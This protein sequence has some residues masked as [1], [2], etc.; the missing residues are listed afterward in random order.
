MRT[1]LFT[2][3]VLLTLLLA[4]PAAVSAADSDTV[5]VT[6]SIGLTMDVTAATDTIPFGSM[7]AG[8]DETGNTVVTVVTTG[9]SW[10]VTAADAKA[11]N[12][13]YMTTNA[14]GSGKKLAGAFQISN[15]ETTF[16]P[17]TSGYAFMSGSSAGTFT[18]TADV[19]QT[20][21]AADSSGSY[22]I[23]VTFT[24]SAS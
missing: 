1:I 6:G 5:Q 17:L 3:L 11:T 8:T 2:G 15:D 19:K 18:D 22:Q 20:I 9:S 23:T 4:L 12:K 24:G 13:G 21:S 16:S 14:D 10:T 7:V